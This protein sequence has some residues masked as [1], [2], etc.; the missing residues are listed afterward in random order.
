MKDLRQILAT[1][2]ML[3][4][5]SASALAVEPQKREEPKQAPP[6]EEKVVPKEEKKEHPRSN[7][8]DN[9]GGRDDNRGNRENN[10]DRRGRP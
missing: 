6:K 9:R 8:G 1:A 2:L 5:M 7:D 4:L 10:N 3:G